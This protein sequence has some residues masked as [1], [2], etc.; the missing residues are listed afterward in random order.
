VPARDAEEM[1]QADP[2]ATYC[3]PCA[4]CSANGRLVLARGA[5]SS[6]SELVVH[7]RRVTKSEVAWMRRP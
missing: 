6:G 3:G 4:C 2:P 1:P 5:A 7:C